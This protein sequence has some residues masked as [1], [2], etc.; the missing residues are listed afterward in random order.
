[1]THDTR[2]LGKDASYEETIAR[3]SDLLKKHNFEIEEVSWQNPVPNVWSVHIKDRNCPQLFSNGKGGS[4]KAALASAL[5][6]FHE[7]LACDYFFREY[8]Y[9][10]EVS[11]SAFVHHP[12]EKWFPI[13]DTFRLDKILP[14]DLASFY[15]RDQALKGEDLVDFNSANV[16]RGI[17]ALPFVRIKD[18]E[19]VYFPINILNNLYVSNGMA[20]GNTIHEARVQ[21]LSEI[22]ERYAKNII[23]SESITL[24][25]IPQDVL[26]KYPAVTEG[27][28]AL[29]KQGFHILVKDASLGKKLPV[30]NVT[31][32][33]PNN[34]GVFA[35]FGA[36]PMF[37]VALERTLT[38]LLQGRSLDKLDQ[39]PPPS[40]DL[41]E[42]ANP[43]NL[44]R[45][46]IDSTGL[47]HLKHLSKNPDYE[48]RQWD[49]KK[50]TGKQY[51]Y[52]TFVIHSMG[53][54]IY[55][56]DYNHFG[57]YCCRIVVPDMS[58]IYPIDDLLEENRALSVPARRAILTPS[59]LDAASSKSLYDFMEERSFP[60]EQLL[61]N[62]AGILPPEDSL[63]ADLCVGEFNTLLCLASKDVEN[64][65][66]WSEW[67]STSSILSSQR[68]K[69]YRCI[70]IILR[71]E[72]ESNRDLSSYHSSL[73]K[74]FGEELFS[75]SVLN[76]DGKSVFDELEDFTINQASSPHAKLIDAYR[77]CQKA[78]ALNS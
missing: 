12:K 50:E 26:N 6:E 18:N 45:H 14:Q 78:K 55:V 27:I 28:N 70:Y 29:E 48:F 24:P 77:D 37:E 20:A 65:I 30:V 76:I 13:D 75:T 4:K 38:E 23:I 72:H 33:N 74:L 5:G 1:M 31:L 41:E 44:E 54:E 36:H 11:Q 7:R 35:A 61:S 53:K 60:R 40:L 56:A 47:M 59:S 66:M 69:R 8:S 15:D 16:D 73:K 22:I 64:A 32:L 68:Q 51:E 3:M 34:S 58:E 57:V 39:F 63:W 52:I 42:V 62:L 43:Y 71:T 49:F 25:D 67:C 46:F 21:A 17:C 10:K 9:E 2:A 19:S